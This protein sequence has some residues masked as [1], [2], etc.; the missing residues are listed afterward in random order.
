VTARVAGSLVVRVRAHRSFVRALPVRGVAEVRGQRVRVLPGRSPGAFCAGLLRPAVYVSEGTLRDLRRPALDAVLAHERH[1][2][3]RRD[4]L[5]LLVT[6]ALADAA[7]PI[8][9]LAALADRHGALA[10][11]AADAAAV[12]ELGDRRPLAAAL[13]AFEDRG[14]APERVDQ[15]VRPAPA[16][17]PGWVCGAA[18]LVAAAAAAPAAAMLLLGWHAHAVLPLPLAAAAACAG[19]AAR[20]AGAFLRVR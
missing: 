7:R 1:H 13:V 14:V 3:D 4:P 20:R 11:L 16:P 5:R 18:A 9:P 10:D 15:L 19:L 6:R 8:P 17:V 12:R 2:R